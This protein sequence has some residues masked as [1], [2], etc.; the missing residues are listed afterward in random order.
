M[1]HLKEFIERATELL[2]DVCKVDESRHIH[3]ENQKIYFQSPK[4]LFAKSKGDYK[5]RALMK[6]AVKDISWN[7]KILIG[8]FYKNCPDGYE[9]D[10]II[11]ISLGGKHKLSNLQYL[12]IE[13]NRS[14]GA[15]LNWKNIDV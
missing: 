15:K 11:P 10:H 13:E 5:R 1:E 4:G 12:T 6:E 3:N 9:V 14:K 7:E 8:N 2:K